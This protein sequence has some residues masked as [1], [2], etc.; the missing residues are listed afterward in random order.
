VFFFTRAQGSSFEQTLKEAAYIPTGPSVAVLPFKAFSYEGEGDGQ[1]RA[2]LI[3]T[4]LNF[5]LIHNLSRFKDLRVITA[6]EDEAHGAHLGVAE[7]YLTGSIQ[8]SDDSLRATSALADTKSGQVVWSKTYDEVLDDAGGILKVQPA[9]ASDV[10]A[11]VGQPYSPVNKGFQEKTNRLGTDNLDNYYCLAR[12]YAYLVVKTAIEHAATRDCLETA[13]AQDENFSSAWAALSWMYGDEQRNGFNEVERPLAPFE[14]AL[15]AAEKAVETDRENAMGYQYFSIANFTLERDDEFKKSA[16][17]A[18]KL[19][20][21]D[22]EVLADIGSH[23]IQLGNVTTAPQ[24][25]EKAILLNPARPPWYHGSLTMYYYVSGD[26]DAALNNAREYNKDGSLAA[27][28][29]YV[30]CNVQ[31][32]LCFSSRAHREVLLNKLFSS[33]LLSGYELRN[34]V[35][36]TVINGQVWIGISCKISCAVRGGLF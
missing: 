16:E 32:G 6:S 5:E 21:N 23:L 2:R 9:I 10:A 27:A 7:Y 28:I 11:A 36:N 26:I 30:V 1:A 18:L 8:I 22:A 35:N 31:A 24:M 14:M 29:L 19:N 15:Q 34:G 17:L 4:G 25:V 20:P 13:V 33:R 3:K 12:F